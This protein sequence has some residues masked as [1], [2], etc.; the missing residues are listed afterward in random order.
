[1]NFIFWQNINSVHQSAF[2][3]A[4]ALNQNNKITLIVSD[5]LMHERSLMGW[6]EPSLAN[7]N[8][9]K[10]DAQLDWKKIILE[11]NSKESIHIF[12]GISAFKKV[13][14]AFD[15]A[16]KNGCKTAI[17]TEALD[18]RGVKGVLRYL[19]G[20]IHKMKYDKHITFVL[21]IGSNC[22]EQFKRW[23]FD[24]AK[25]FE[26][27]YT[28]EKVNIVI[29]PMDGEPYKIIYA[30][31][32]LHLKGI[33]LLIK[34]LSALHADRYNFDIYTSNSFSNSY[35]KGIKSLILKNQKIKLFPFIDN[36][37]LKQKISEYDLL[38]LPS[39]YD[40]WGG[41]VSEAIMIGTPVLVSEN[42]GSHT[43]VNNNSIAGKIIKELTVSGIARDLH[44]LIQKGKQNPTDRELLIEWANA[45][46]S[47][48]AMANYF[49]GIMENIKNGGL[50]PNA[51]WV[52]GHQI[53]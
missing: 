45:H 32:L 29:K 21:A 16:V 15:Y 30:G 14:M 22:V 33:D 48:K 46:I 23:G 52:K 18:F 47:G 8:L 13:Q 35:E 26:W 49:E 38:V 53:E 20:F 24:K 10:F 5:H 44:Q 9:V 3:N 39:R 40:G 28:I 1:M 25:I 41:V 2:F 27:A 4:A 6:K 43:V 50:K 17:L 12:S 19:R 7:V 42:C 36:N 34:S 31:S 37:L 11:N 51:P